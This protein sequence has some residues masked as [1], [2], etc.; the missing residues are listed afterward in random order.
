M[1]KIITSIT[2]PLLL[3]LIL[4]C[5]TDNP[6][7]IDGEWVSDIPFIINHVGLHYAHDNRI[8]ESDHFLTF[9]DA[10]SDAVKKRFAGYAERAFAE[11]L[12]DFHIPSASSLGITGQ[13]TKMTIYTNKQ[14]GMIQLAFPYGF[15]LDGEDSQTYANWPEEMKPRYYKQLKHET[16]HV[17]QFLLGVLPNA[18]NDYEP[19]KWFNEGLA[20]TMSG[21]FFIPITSRAEFD[22]WKSRCGSVNPV[23]IHQWSDLTIPANEVGAFYPAFGLAVRYLV[24]KDGLGKRYTDIK[25]MFQELAMLEITFPEA[26]EKYMGITLEEYENTFFERMDNFL[27]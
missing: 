5:S 23:S 9:S 7:A 11:I 27:K 21:G 8:F 13:S 22:S 3:L 24:H 26:F 1:T 12:D 19:D 16:M 2:A 25:H 17:V 6:Y 10:G 20:E 4:E 14:S 18:D 15:I